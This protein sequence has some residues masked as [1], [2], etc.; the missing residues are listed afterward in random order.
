VT[1]PTRSDALAL[2]AADELA[3][4]VE[5]FVVADPQLCYLDG[6]S[7]GRL[8][9]AVASRLAD[10]V[11][12]EWGTE[13]VRGWDRWLD[14]PVT[15]G[16]RIAPL[17]GAHPGEVVACDSTTVNLYKVAA[18]ALDARPDRP[19]IL[20]PAAEFPTDRYVLEGL[21]RRTGRRIRHASPSEADEQTALAVAS[22]VDFRTAAVADVAGA[23]AAAHGAGALVCWDL[24]HAAGSVAVDLGAAHADL[25]IGCTYKHLCGGPG[26]PAYLYVRRE[27]QREL[28]SPIWGW[29]G[30]RDQFA[31][32][33]AY[34]PHDDIRRFLTGTTNV[35]GL[36]AVDAAVALVAEAGIA[37]L[38]VKGRALT[39]LVI[40]FADEHLSPLGLSVA[41]PR[42]ASERGAHVALAHP[43][44]YRIGV[45]ALAEGVAPDV[46]P[47][48]LVRIGPAP[49]S[50]RFVEV[51]DGLDRIRSLVAAGA[52]LTVDP[53]RPRVT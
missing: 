28:T 38:Q 19:E 49:I 17:I 34:E 13:L 44:A 18:A 45:A 25:A 8:P 46:R 31:M 35:L 24:S 29:F 42:A 48:D 9:V 33:P 3:P 52:H 43:E 37:R 53:T 2:D 4:F 14:L 41:S 21:A 23:T 39:E 47:P 40:A 22:V 1:A 27:L 50:T 36:V 16:D 30:Q 51:W 12:A 11:Q 10:A 15:V 5:R 32:G 20:V 7:L 6:N 26:A